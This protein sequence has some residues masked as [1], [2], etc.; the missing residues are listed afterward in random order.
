MI[1]LT[2]LVSDNEDAF[3]KS[4]EFYSVVTQMNAGEDLIEQKTMLPASDKF[5]SILITM[6]SCL[7]T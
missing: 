5:V 7:S 1:N 4:Q 6:V 2:T 3:F